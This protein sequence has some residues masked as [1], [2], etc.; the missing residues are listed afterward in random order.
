MTGVDAVDSDLWVFGYGS[1]I[2]RPDF[3]FIARREGFITGWSRRFWQASHDHRG[4]PESPG[5]VATIIASPGSRCWGVAY[6]VAPEERANVLAYL[7]DR[8]CGG[9]ERRFLA[10]HSPGEETVSSVLVYIAAH[11]NPNYCGPEEIAASAARVR[12]ACGLRGPNSEYVLQLAAALTHMGADDPHVFELAAAL[13]EATG[14]SIETATHV[15]AA[16]AEAAS[17]PG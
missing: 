7:D 6:R 3:P 9:Y 4:T 16:V 10:F 1:L 8:E 13:A 11:D 17:S 15:L 12:A 14:T 2:F 5:R